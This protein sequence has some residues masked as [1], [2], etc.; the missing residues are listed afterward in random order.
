MKG[1]NGILAN[2]I[3]RTAAEEKS[4]PKKE[5]SA[6]KKNPKLEMKESMGKKGK[7]MKGMM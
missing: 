3:K 1:M 4:E 2:L 5:K 6:E 7:K